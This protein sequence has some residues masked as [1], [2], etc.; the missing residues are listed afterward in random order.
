MIGRARG[1]LGVE[2]RIADVGDVIV[3]RERVLHRR[4]PDAHSH[5][6]P[7]SVLPSRCCVH[8]VPEG[9]LALEVESHGVAHLGDEPPYE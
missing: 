2:A 4:L 7:M 6:S 9:Q 5:Q 3:T 1:A 8:D